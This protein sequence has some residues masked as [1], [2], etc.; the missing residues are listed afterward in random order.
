MYWGS[1]VNK[2]DDYVKDFLAPS[3]E[4]DLTQQYSPNKLSKDNILKI[5]PKSKM[6]QMKCLKTKMLLWYLMILR[7]WI[8]DKGFD[9]QGCKT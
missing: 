7:Q 1:T 2:T 8:A 4:I 6:K 3:L 9:P 5:V